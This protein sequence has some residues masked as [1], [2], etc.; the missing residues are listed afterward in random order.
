LGE[1][2]T[3]SKALGHVALSGVSNALDL[4]GQPALVLD[5]LGFV[6]NVN[7]VAEQ[8]FDDELFVRERRLIARDQRAN[9]ALS[10]LTD[11]LRT[12][13]DTAVLAAEPIII[14]R[15]AKRP[16]VIRV[17][18]VDGTARSPFL[19]AR[20]LLVFSDLDRETGPRREEL[21][22]VFGLSPAES[23]LATLLVAGMSLDRAAE[24]LRLSRETV[25]NQLKAIFAKTATHRQSEL[26]ALLARL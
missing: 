3:L 22:R 23:R 20:V 16:V 14:R 25:R 26:V 5:R 24:Q 17:L 11:Q 21:A 2:A 9:A 18:P 19:G 15:T 4:V 7:A 8:I 13:R 12:T 10:E 1:I 6:L